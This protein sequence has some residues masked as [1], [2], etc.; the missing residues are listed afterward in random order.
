MDKICPHVKGRCVG[1]A[2]SEFT[3]RYRYTGYYNFGMPQK[4]GIKKNIWINIY[5]M[6]VKGC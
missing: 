1:K 2:C 6:S 5:M 3:P 4:Y